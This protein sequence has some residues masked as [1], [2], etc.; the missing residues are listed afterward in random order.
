MVALLVSIYLSTSLSFL[1][2]HS[3]KQGEIGRSAVIYRR[4][5]VYRHPARRRYARRTATRRRWFRLA[6]EKSQA[7]LDVGL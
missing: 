4:S 7:Q 5:T 6:V 2:I 1:S 3:E